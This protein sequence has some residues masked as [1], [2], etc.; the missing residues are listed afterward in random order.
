M[1]EGGLILGALVI[2][3]FLAII[4]FLAYLISKIEE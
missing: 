1:M 2:S 3:G 4:V